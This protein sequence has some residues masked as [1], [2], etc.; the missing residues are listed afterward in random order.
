MWT[1]NHLVNP[2]VRAL[3][4]SPLHPL[5]S[6]RLVLLR[7]RGRRS[8]RTIELPVAYERHGRT[9]S[10]QVGHPEAK[11]W[12]R[13]IGVATPVGVVLD[14]HEIEGVAGRLER[15]PGRVEVKIAV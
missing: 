4:R 12:W 9:L 2:L 14:G 11:R 6:H 15:G 8:G 1:L 7:V 5:L 13:N 10:V 3:L